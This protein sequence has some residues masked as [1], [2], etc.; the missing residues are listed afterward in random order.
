MERLRRFGGAR[1]G[2]AGG[3]RRPYP[4][5][6]EVGEQGAEDGGPEGTSDGPEERHTRCRDSEVG[7]AGGVLDDQDEDLRIGRC[8]CRGRKDT[9]T[10]AMWVLRRPSGRAARTPPP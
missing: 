8:R 3:E 9:A 6:E 4:A 2:P 7:E 5:G 10:V 1:R